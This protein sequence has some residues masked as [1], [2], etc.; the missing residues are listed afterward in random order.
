MQHLNSIRG[1]PPQVNGNPEPSTK[2]AQE[3][4]NINVEPNKVCNATVS[5]IKHDFKEA[6]HTLP[7]DLAESWHFNSLVVLSIHKDVCGLFKKFGTFEIAYQL[8]VLAM[9][10][11]LCC[12][13][14][15]FLIII[16]S[17]MSSCCD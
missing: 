6:S 4:N 5:Q 8:D 9:S 3:Y 1:N 2:R 10:A 17:A 16:L 14:A 7:I 12:L 13:L 11:K 15:C